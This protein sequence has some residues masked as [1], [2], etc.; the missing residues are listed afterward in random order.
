VAS[1]SERL[2]MTQVEAEDGRHL[3]AL[4]LEDT[5]PDARALVEELEAGGFQVTHHRVDSRE[6]FAEALPDARWDIVLAGDTLR[7]SALEAL[8]L[9]RQNRPD[10]PLLLVSHSAR[11]EDSQ[12]ALDAGAHDFVLKDHLT[13]LLPAV[14]RA[15][16]AKED[17]R[18]REQAEQAL[19]ESEERYRELVENANDVVLRVNLQGNF[20]SMNRAGE[21]ISGYTREELTRMNMHQVLTPESFQRA[22]QMIVQKLAD[23]R[24]TV[25]ELKMIAR[26]GHHVPLELSTRLIYHDGVPTGIQGIARDITKRKRGEQALAESAARYRGLFENASDIVYTHDLT[27]HFTSINQAAEQVTGYSR[28]EVIGLNIAD[29]VAPDHVELARTMI[30]RKLD[31]QAPTTYELDIVS[32]FGRRSTIEVNS[33]LTYQNGKPI[34]VQG[35]AR[36]VTER[37]RA[38]EELRAR[39]RK[40]AAVAQL[41]QHALV[42]TDLSLLFKDT[43]SWV[44]HTLDVAYCTILERSDDGSELVGRAGSGWNTDL[45]GSGR[46]GAGP[47][48]F[49]G[50]T[51][52]CSEPVIVEDFSK[53]TRFSIPRILTAHDVQ[54]GMSVIVAGSQTPFGV[55]TVFTDAPRDFSHDDVHF[56][57]SVA[58]VLAAAI[59]RKRLED[60]RAHH[61]QEL[62]TRVLQA[63]EEERKRIARELHDDTAQSLSMLLTNLDL[64]EPSIE[65]GNA[66]LS[67]GFRRV[68][69]LA[70][71]T[72]DAVRSISHDLRPT[73]LDDAGLEAALEWVAAEYERE[74]HGAAFVDTRVSD[75]IELTAEIEVALFRIA[76]EALTNSGKH[77]GATTVWIRLRF[78]ERIAV[79][80]IEDNGRGFD[81]TSVPRPTRDGRLGMYG[82]RERATLFGGPLTV[83]TSP[84]KGTVVRATLPLPA[85]Q[86]TGELQPVF[87]VERGQQ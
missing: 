82:M 44:V 74:F 84:G 86:T 47:Q 67:A 83:T 60:E 5:E 1:R 46:V 19:R 13:R 52:L 57:Q 87:T 16:R 65:A 72:L 78:E 80:T 63:Q 21:L 26:D 2:G 64:L 14:E 55:L 66:T 56:L 40:Q 33:Q 51:L 71:R 37:R 73:I 9:V 34:G 27:G 36:D 79:L 58:N 77:A 32:K 41:G 76:Q 18:T 8:S 35:I 68:A 39:E 24:P 7:L 25:Y 70:R 62:A 15:V 23:N 69:S 50:F 29:I 45:V 85:P 12:K 20:T 11:E 30:Q 3:S 48:S 38:E 53:E 6:T 75:D 42:S 4:I 22:Q 28:E 17:R 10:L 43:V 31:E 61:T 59:E 49:A 54:S 81:P